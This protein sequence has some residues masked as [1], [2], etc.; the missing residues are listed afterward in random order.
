MRFNLRGFALPAFV[1]VAVMM[2]VEVPGGTT[3]IYD[4]VNER[5]GIGPGKLPDL[6]SKLVQADR[7]RNQLK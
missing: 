3:E 5:M 2:M 6:S 7:G 4:S 1:M